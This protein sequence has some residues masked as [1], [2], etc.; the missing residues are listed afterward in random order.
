[1]GLLLIL[2]LVGGGVVCLLCLPYFRMYKSGFAFDVTVSRAGKMI[3]SHEREFLSDQA[4]AAS[5]PIFAPRA[6]TRD[7]GP[8]IGP[9]IHWTRVKPGAVDYAAL[10]DGAIDRG[11]FDK[12][13]E[14]W[15]NA[16][17]E[18]WHRLDFGWMA[19]LAQFDYW[20]I[21]KNSVS[22]PSD[23]IGPDPLSGDLFAWAELRLAKGLHENTLSSAVAEVEELARLCFT[24]ERHSLGLYGIALL[25][26]I[27]RAREKAR[28]PRFEADLGR[29]NRALWGAI[30]FARL[31]TPPEY[32]RDYDHLV[33]G[34]C[35]ALQY[36]AWSAIMTRPELRESRFREYGRLDLLLARTP[37]C[38]LGRI[39]QRWALSDELAAPRDA[40]S[41]WW[42]RLLWRWSPAWRR[43]QGEILVAIGAQDWFKRYDRVRANN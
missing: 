38:R 3:A 42:E 12:I 11:I 8:L 28:L 18:L 26:D 31:E 24:T 20:D 15:L 1:M 35:A 10:S 37:E 19:Q 22:D 43:V 9:R 40:S 23:L 5:L 21:E 36:G 30:A 7:A 34:R 41:S 14:D 29:I 27:R 39:R 32:A 4:Y 25:A 2:V 13:G 16:P 33:V 17:P 6:G